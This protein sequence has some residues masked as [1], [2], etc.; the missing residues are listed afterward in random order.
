MNL[1]NKITVARIVMI[2]IFLIV[3]NVDG[4]IAVKFGEEIGKV[5]RVT[6]L[7]FA[8]LAGFTDILDGY[9]ARKYN[10]VTDFGRLMDP[11]ADKIFMATTFIM[12]VDKQILSGWVAVVVLS[13]EFLVTGLRL[14]ATNKGEVISA[15]VTGKLKT[16]LQMAFLAIGGSVWVGWFTKKD[17]I[18]LWDISVWVIVVVTVYSGVSYFF[19]FRH[20]YLSG[21]F[22]KTGKEKTNQV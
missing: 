19:R 6:G 5:W 21:S 14:L 22:P 17:I 1:P 9:I 11:L 4:Y 12:L 7:V 8:I 16:S 15:D 3:C 20:L 10:L 13:R 2:F 18:L